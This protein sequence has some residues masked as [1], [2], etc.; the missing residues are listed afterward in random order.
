MNDINQNIVDCYSLVGEALIRSSGATAVEVKALEHLLRATLADDDDGGYQ[1][2][3]MNNVDNEIGFGVSGQR[4]QSGA[5][6]VLLLAMHLSTRCGN[7]R[8]REQDP[9]SSTYILISEALMRPSGVTT[10][11]FNALQ[12][13]LK[14]RFPTEVVKLVQITS[15]STII[16]LSVGICISGQVH[17]GTSAVV[18]LAN[19]YSK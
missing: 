9:T 1:L 3:R 7:E 15:S 5:S 8:K 6:A 17:I 4:I 2:V 14:D 18:L 10:L 13:L 11:E 12:N 19:C 16:N